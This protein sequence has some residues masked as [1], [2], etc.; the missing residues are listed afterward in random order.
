MFR[1]LAVS[2]L[3]LCGC[4]LRATL[5]PA[6]GEARVVLW[7][8]ADLRG[9]DGAELRLPPRTVVEVREIQNGRC[10]VDARGSAAQV[11]G[12]VDCV[13]LGYFA[14]RPTPVR[15]RP[16][17]PV[18]L[19][20][21]GGGLFA[22]RERRGDW[23]KV[24]GEAIGTFDGWVRAADLG[25]RVD[26][27]WLAPGLPRHPWICEDG[28][29]LYDNPKGTFLIWLPSP[30]CRVSL[31]EEREGWTRI[32]Y[33]DPRIKLEGWVQAD[34]LKPD[35]EPRFHP[36]ARLV[37]IQSKAEVFSSPGAKGPFAHL[38]AGIRVWASLTSRGRTMVQTHGSAVEVIGW[39]ESS[40]LGK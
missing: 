3:L 20:L 2:S 18:K 38:D 39:V 11:R 15:I 10:R 33:L 32:E 34:S 5:Y 21:N 26:E 23:V 25:T 22:P 24:E 4:P 9:P 17:G 28:S 27:E 16:D 6:K 40:R 31:L 30:W 7:D 35:P 8:G 14:R 19:T 36:G 29:W 12:E 13:R 37:S 1:T